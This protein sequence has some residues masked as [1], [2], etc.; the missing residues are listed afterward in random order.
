MKVE[1]IQYQHRRNHNQFSVDA[2][3]RDDGTIV[4]S[5]HVVK[6]EN[7]GYKPDGSISTNTFDA[8]T[9]K[10]LAQTSGDS[11]AWKITEVEKGHPTRCGG[12][13]SFRHKITRNTQFPDRVGG[14]TD[15]PIASYADV[16]AADY[17]ML[18]LAI[19]RLPDGEKKRQ[20]NTAFE[21]ATYDMGYVPLKGDKKDVVVS[22]EKRLGE[23]L[24]QYTVD[25]AAPE[26]TIQV[27]EKCLNAVDTIMLD[28]KTFI[29]S[30]HLAGIKG[31]H[32]E[33]RTVSVVTHEMDGSVPKDEP[34]LRYRVKGQSSWDI[35][36]SGFAASPG[37]RLTFAIL[38]EAIGKLPNGAR[39]ELLRVRFNAAAQ[40]MG[41]QREPKSQVRE[42]Q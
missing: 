33:E 5:S 13:P 40:E 32:S 42:V 1:N 31:S 15:F 8:A 41:Y 28:P 11:V 17:D 38:D 37:P 34:V 18:K 24:Y 6:Y 20:L 4:I 30:K 9:M 19:D 14:E 25:F 23:H 36:K 16:M 12:K 10:P 2:D 22:G 7:P 39:K 35:P 3:F 29:P 26:G 27:V 21:A